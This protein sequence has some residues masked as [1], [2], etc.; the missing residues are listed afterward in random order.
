MSIVPPDSLRLLLKAT[1]SEAKERNW[2]AFVA[3]FSPLLLHTART[4][5]GGRDAIMD[6][7]AFAI[8][9]LRADD[10]RRLRSFDVDRPGKFS[11][12]LIAVVRRLCIDEYRRRYG[13]PQSVGPN[14]MRWDARRQLVDL[15]GAA[16]DLE[17]LALP[18]DQA[19]DEVLSRA[20]LENVLH[21][22]V[23]QLDTSDRLL[24]RL[25]FEDGCSVPEIAQLLDAPSPFH[26]YRRI[27]RLL[28][29]LRQ[30]LVAM[31]IEGSRQ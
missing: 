4:L 2:S 28:A 6:R 21:T 16:I 13:R 17:E 24:L 29:L 25:R 27:D 19:P 11:T 5:G 14:T 12:W 31:G 26:V 18:S 20:E 30:R 15:V 1:D 3:E 8:E 10:F 22:A 23:L 7:Y 9:A